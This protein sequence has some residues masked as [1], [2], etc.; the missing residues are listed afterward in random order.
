[1]HM[2]AESCVILTGKSWQYHVQN[3]VVAYA[4]SWVFDQN[5]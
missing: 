4:Q 5:R 1:M 2:K 3:T